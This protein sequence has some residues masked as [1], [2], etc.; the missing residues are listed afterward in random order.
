MSEEEA[1]SE[2]AKSEGE[3]TAK[4]TN[5]DKV[6]RTLTQKHSKRRKNANVSNSAADSLNL[7]DSTSSKSRWNIKSLWRMNMPS[8]LCKKPPSKML[9]DFAIFTA[10]AL[11]IY[12]YGS[13]MNSWI[14]EQ[15]PSEASLREKM[16][17]AQARMAAA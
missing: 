2:V 5:E 17:E 15:V 14:Q 3:T 4:E 9:L 7:S 1:K 10:G 16:A 12:N 13:S 6:K 8:Y 11:I